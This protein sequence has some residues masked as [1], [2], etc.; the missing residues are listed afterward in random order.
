MCI[1]DSVQ[2]EV[3]AQKQAAKVGRVMTVLCDGY[4]EENELYLCRSE[5]DA[6]DIDAE[7]CVS[8]EAPLYPGT[9]YTVRIKDSDVYDLYAELAGDAPAE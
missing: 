7:V 1:R 9:F 5:A 2:A 8:S 4:D 6:P 3:M